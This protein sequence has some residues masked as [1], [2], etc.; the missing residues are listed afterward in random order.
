[1]KKL[2]LIHG[3]SQQNKDA[4]HLK[5]EW[6]KSLNGSFSKA[7]LE[8]P[9]KET[10]IR[11]PY[12]GDTLAQLAAGQ[13]GDDVAK[14]VVRGE[15]GDE[16]EAQF[17][18]EV[19]KEVRDE[20]GITDRQ[21]EEVAD[22]EEIERGVLSWPWVYASLQTID[23]YLPGGSAASIALATH[24]VYVYLRNPGIRDVIEAGVRQALDES[25]A[26]VV[27]HSLGSV[28]AYNLL[29]RDGVKN[30]WKV[31]I[32]ITVGSPL[33]V[34][35]IR[36]RLNPLQLPSCVGTWYNARDR[37]DIVALHP[38]NSRSGWNLNPAIENYEDVVNTTSNHHGISGYLGDPQV[39]AK[40]HAEL[41]S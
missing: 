14:V 1:M 27:A 12:Y 40:I 39:A 36:E 9:I 31:P 7:G 11:F 8:M 19:L 41:V 21:V 28:V 5:R 16:E 18:L 26:V 34:R 37:R 33:A 23:K 35:A 22:E 13:S 6:L 20:H 2:I 17:Q 4:V 10:S 15:L 25:P 32:L 24:D 3:R 30:G 29:R 38:L